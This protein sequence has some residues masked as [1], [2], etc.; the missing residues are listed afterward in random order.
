MAAVSIVNPDHMMAGQDLSSGCKGFCHCF[1]RILG[2][3]EL[4]FISY[5]SEAIMYALI[6]DASGRAVT[7]QD[8]HTISSR[9]LRSYG[10]C[11]SSGSGSD[12]NNSPHHFTSPENN[13]LPALRKEIS[14]GFMPYSLTSM[15]TILVR[16]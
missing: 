10:C 5:Q 12:D 11:Q 8:N 6:Q 3:G 7:L 15:S 4:F 13:S 16:Q 1:L 2:S 9:L 14:L